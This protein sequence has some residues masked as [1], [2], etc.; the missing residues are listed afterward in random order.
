MNISRTPTMLAAIAT[1]TAMALGAPSASAQAIEAQDEATGQHCNPCVA[2]FTGT[3]TIER[4]LLGMETVESQCTSEFDMEV[5]EDGTAEIHNQTLHGANC[6]HQ[7]CDSATESEWPASAA[8]TGP[9]Q[10]AFATEICLE[11]EGGGAE[12]HCSVTMV[13][14]EAA[15]HNYEA[16]M[17]GTCNQAIAP[18]EVQGHWVTEAGGIEFIHT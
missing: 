10:L 13:M 2:H 3:V 4:H 14:A 5:N 8:E 6:N 9:A 18:L 12:E 16:Q 15:S 7:A 11:P 17:D 1:L